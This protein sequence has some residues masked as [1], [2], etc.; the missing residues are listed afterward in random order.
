MAA[1]PVPDTTAETLTG[2]VA[3]SAEDGATVYTDE[4]RSYGPLSGLGYD[5]A[6]VSHSASEYVRGDIHVNGIES[7]WSMLKRGYMGTYHQVSEEHLHRYINE[8]TGRHNIRP[9][10]TCEQ[11]G[12][13]ADGL[14]GRRLAYEELVTV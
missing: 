8:F 12:R 7:L 1:A 10:D 14:V 4:H 6:A 2:M 11:M 3:G 13:V 9:L 5:H